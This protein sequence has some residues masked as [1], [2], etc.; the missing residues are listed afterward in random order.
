MPKFEF[1][2]KLGPSVELHVLRALLD[3]NFEFCTILTDFL[4][5]FFFF[6]IITN[7]NVL[8]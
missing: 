6:W 2:G 4:K 1:G 3:L 7:V 5:V 8:L